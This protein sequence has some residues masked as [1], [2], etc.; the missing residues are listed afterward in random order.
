DSEQRLPEDVVDLVRAGVVEVLALEED[1]R[2]PCVLGEA[3]H[4]GQRGRAPGVVPVQPRELLDELR[5]RHRLDPGGVQLIQGGDQCL[6]DEPTT[7][8]AESAQLLS[9]A[10]PPRPTRR[11][12]AARSSR[13]ADRG[14]A[15][16]TSASPT[17]TARAPAAT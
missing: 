9:H 5:V 4:L 1:P 7:E 2:A 11:P 3:R 6:R 8:L 17:S 13:T 12:P 10:V 15:P 14:S 16:V